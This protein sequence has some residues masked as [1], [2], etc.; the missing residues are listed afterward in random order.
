MPAKRAGTYK[1]RKPE[2]SS[3]G[4]PHIESFVIRAILGPVR[5]LKPRLQTIEGV[6]RGLALYAMS[7]SVPL[8]QA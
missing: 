6:T 4:F 5:H 7:D 2:L 3:P 8:R 1:R